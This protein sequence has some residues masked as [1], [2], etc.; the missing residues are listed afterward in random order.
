MNPKKNFISLRTIQLKSSGNPGWVESFL[1]S[2]MQSG[3]LKMREMSRENAYDNGIV[4][5]PLY[6]IMR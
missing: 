6:M 4:V 3:G 1:V 2:L 5:P